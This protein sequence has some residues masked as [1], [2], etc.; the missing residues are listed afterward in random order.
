MK[1]EKIIDLIKAI[2]T[3]TQEL[4]S[5]L[6]KTKLIK[7]LYLVDVEYYRKYKKTFTSF[8]WICYDYGPWTYEYN[9]IYDQ[10]KSSPDFKVVEKEIPKNISFITCVDDP[11]DFSDIFKELED[12]MLFRELINKWATEELNEILNYVYFY[13]EPMIGTKKKE[14]LDFSKINKFET[15]PKFKLEKGGLSSQEIRAIRATLKEKLR[16]GKEK[17]IEEVVQPKYDE[18]YWQEMEKLD[19]DNEY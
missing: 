7:L 1:I 19:Y 9:D 18:L 2:C 13:T 3:R 6:N 12:S 8:D 5:Y 15:I 14:K 4:E 11:K 17:D 16:R 10:I